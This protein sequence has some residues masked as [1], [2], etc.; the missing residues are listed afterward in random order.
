M[1]APIFFK[2]F[3]AL[4]HYL[5]MRYMNALKIDINYDYRFNNV[6]FKRYLYYV[7]KKESCILVNTFNF[8]FAM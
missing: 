4:Y 7:N 8:F 1:L 2:A 3:V 6:K 5:C